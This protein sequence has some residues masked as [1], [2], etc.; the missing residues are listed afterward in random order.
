MLYIT[1]T[2]DEILKINIFTNIPVFRGIRLS[3][4][5]HRLLVGVFRKQRKE[6]NSSLLFE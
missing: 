6:R 3:L 4:N 1:I 5:M 2:I